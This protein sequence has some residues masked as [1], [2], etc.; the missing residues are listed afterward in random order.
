MPGRKALPGRST[1]LPE[2]ASTATAPPPP[3][4][5][6]F[7]PA[8][9]LVLQRTRPVAPSD[10]TRL[11]SLATASVEAGEEGW[12]AMGAA[13]SATHTTLDDGE[14]KPM[15]K[16]P[17]SE[18]R[19]EPGDSVL[20]MASRSSEAHSDGHEIK[21]TK[22]RMAMQLVKKKLVKAMDCGL[23]DLPSSIVVL[24]F[25]KRDTTEDMSGLSSGFS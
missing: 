11:P 16:A 25:S 10:K 23:I 6:E 8:V 17:P 15:A 7:T 1:R 13:W 5:D 21:K 9:T 4:A 22:R 14:K 24:P 18:T 19:V 3:D 12:S 20:P 2:F